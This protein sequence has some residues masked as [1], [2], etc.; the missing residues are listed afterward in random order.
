VAS[1]VKRAD[2]EVAN[3]YDLSIMRSL[4][5]F[6]AAR[7]IYPHREANTRDSKSETVPIDAIFL[8]RWWYC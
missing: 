2:E 8:D 1:E 4:Y 5:A 6:G 7:A 3:K